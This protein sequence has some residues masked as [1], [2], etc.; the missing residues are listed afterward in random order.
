EADSQVRLG[1][2]GAPDTYSV[3]ADLITAQP[4]QWSVSRRSTKPAPYPVLISKLGKK[5][6]NKSS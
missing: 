4:Q 2:V 3:C 6:I 5:V 1:V